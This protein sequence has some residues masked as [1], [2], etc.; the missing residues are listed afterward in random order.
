MDGCRD[1][2][3]T[4]HL[5]L[6]DSGMEIHVLLPLPVTRGADEDDAELPYR[7]GEYT[8]HLPLPEF[9]MLAMVLQDI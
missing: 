6:P 2:E 1:G 5:P 8:F 9:G 4:F 3:Y 7:D